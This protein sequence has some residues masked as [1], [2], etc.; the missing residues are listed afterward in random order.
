MH[1]LQNGEVVVRHQPHGYL[2]LHLELAR[3]VAAQGARTLHRQSE[4]CSRRANE[5][6][7]A[8][9]SDALT[10]LG[11]WTT[12]HS[13]TSVAPRRPRPG[14]RIASKAKAGAGRRARRP[15]A[16]SLARRL[17]RSDRARRTP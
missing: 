15:R 14:A 1:L 9:T 17:R 6:P 7:V 12:W 4:T 3:S 8:T 13:S 2:P 5:S 10:R 16:I 11:I